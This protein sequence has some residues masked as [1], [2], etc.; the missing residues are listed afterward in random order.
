MMYVKYIP[1]RNGHTTHHGLAK[2]RTHAHSLLPV[3]WPPWTAVSALL[4]LISMAYSQAKGSHIRSSIPPLTLEANPKVVLN[5]SI[6]NIHM[7]A[8]AGTN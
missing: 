8:V 2:T 3:G 1:K 7:G 5:P 4:G 6:I